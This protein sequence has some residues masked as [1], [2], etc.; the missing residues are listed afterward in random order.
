[1]I[2]RISITAI[3]ILAVASSCS[4]DIETSQRKETPSSDTVKEEGGSISFL[5]DS[6]ELE[7]EEEIVRLRKT[8]SVIPTEGAN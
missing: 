7:E 5:L 2:R 8:P 6:D 1:M 4:T 3:G